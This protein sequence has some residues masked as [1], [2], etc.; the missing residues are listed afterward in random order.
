V[1]LFKTR[2]DRAVIPEAQD[3]LWEALGR[4]RRITLPF[5]HIGLALAFYYVV[6]RGAEFLW[7]R[8]S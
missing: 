8:L 2:H 6:R 5:G 3:K 7:E 4:P 1:L